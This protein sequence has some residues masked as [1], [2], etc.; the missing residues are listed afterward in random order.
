MRHFSKTRN[1]I[2]SNQRSTVYE[3]LKIN[4][5][6]FVLFL[7]FPLFINHTIPTVGIP[8]QIDD[9]LGFYEVP[10]R[11][12]RKAHS[13]AALATRAP[14]ACIPL[15]VKTPSK[16]SWQRWMQPAPSSNVRMASGSPGTIGRIGANPF[17]HAQPRPHSTPTIQFDRP[18]DSPTA[19]PQLWPPRASHQLASPPNCYFPNPDPA[20]NPFNLRGSR[21]VG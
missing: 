6:R 17:P 20:A 8:N 10:E 11:E 3:W 15:Y 5:L 1:F 2:F 9:V 12:G 16:H 19:T 21:I 7:F 13:A 4:L 18:T 14:R